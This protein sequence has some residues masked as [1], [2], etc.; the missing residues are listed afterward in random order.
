MERADAVYVRMARRLLKN[1]PRYLRRIRMSGTATVQQQAVLPIPIEKVLQNYAKTHLQ[2]LEVLEQN[3]AIRAMNAE[4]NR[5]LDEAKEKIAK[6][7]AD[8]PPR[9]TPEPV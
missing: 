4:L 9:A 5:Q 6:L 7:E 8:P 3:A 1:P 2:F